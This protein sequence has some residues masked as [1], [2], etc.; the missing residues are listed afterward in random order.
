MKWPLP[1]CRHAVTHFGVWKAVEL[2]FS[3]AFTYIVFPETFLRFFPSRLTALAWWGVCRIKSGRLSSHTFL[4]SLF[5]CLCLVSAG[6]ADPLLLTLELTLF[7]FQQLG[8]QR[9]KTFLGLDKLQHLLTDTLYTVL[10]IYCQIDNL[11]Q[12][13]S[14]APLVL[15]VTFL[16]LALSR[17]LTWKAATLPRVS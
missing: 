8:E 6:Y 9:N 15:T 11:L 5:L 12:T 13:F 14:S 7:I 17:N 3:F 4:H 10:Y 1:P 2:Y 16:P